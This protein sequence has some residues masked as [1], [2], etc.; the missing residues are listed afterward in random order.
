VPG[1]LFALFSMA[2]IVFAIYR[3]PAETPPDERSDGW[4]RDIGSVS[5]PSVLGQVVLTQLPEFAFMDSKGDVVK[6]E[7]LIVEDDLAAEEDNSTKPDTMVVEDGSEEPDEQEKEKGKKKPTPA[8]RLVP[9]DE[10]NSRGPKV[11]PA[12]TSASHRAGP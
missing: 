1:A 7:P 4:S 11:I 5:S 10:E 6:L 9:L 3:L 2:I 8:R 12:G